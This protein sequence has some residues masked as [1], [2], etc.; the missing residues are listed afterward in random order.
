MEGA[1]LSAVRIA[2]REAPYRQFLGRREPSVVQFPPWS[3]GKSLMVEQN[4]FH[5]DHAFPAT[6]SQD[7]MY[8]ALI[9]P[10]VDK[11][12]EGFQC[13]AL[14]YGQTGTGKSYSMGMTPPDKI[15][16][17]H[18]GILPRA[19]SDIF[20]R[21]TARQENN[22]DAIQVYASFIEIYNEKPFDL[23]GST[24]H[25]PMVAARCQRCTCLPLH[26]QADLNH[27]LEL[28]TG[29][30]RVRPTN[31]NSN[32]SRSHAIVTIHV[33]NKTHHSR[34]N[35]VD[36]AGSEGVRRTGHEG[37]A[38]QEGVNINLGL[39]SIN[40]VVMSMAAGH[41]VIPYRDSVLTTVLQASLTAQSYL[42]FLACISPHRCDLSETLSTLRF[43]TSAKKLRLNPM[44]VARQKQSLAARTTHVLRQALCTSTAIKPNAANHNSLVVPSSKYSTTK[45]LSG[46]LHRTRSE[47][48]MTPKAKK[49]ARKLLELEETTLELSSIHITDN[50]LSLLGFHSDSDKDRH[51]MPPPTGLETRQASSQN[52]TLMG[53]AEEAEHKES[54]KVQQS[55]VANTVPTTVRCQLFNTTIS[56]ISLR[57]SN[58]Q[59]E[60][61][62]IQPMEETIVASPQQ[63]CLR[64]SM[65]LANSMR[66]QN[67]GAIPKVTNLRRS[68]RL[69]GIR[70][71]ATSVV[72]KNE[73]D[74]IPRPRGAVQKKR[75]RKV[76]PAPK[77][78]MANNTRCFLDLL[79]NGNVKQLQEIPGIGPKF[80]FSL[81]L[82]RSRLGC[83]ENLFQ[84]KSLPIWSG[85]K[86][87]RFCQINCL[88]T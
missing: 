81:A 30:R 21:V 56:P 69:A 73:T 65:R 5:F 32:S 6:I 45:P 27:I 54:S 49:R 38:R 57:A 47:L 41:T 64:R 84:V 35:I 42:T 85:N 48:G 15:L 9:L 40:K 82:H 62:G 87:E 11:L 70:E 59:R 14:A 36:L 58:S 86:W 8:Q 24:P 52:S 68:T 43:G 60:L 23:L 7:E 25:M 34:M 67:Y 46:V 31:M 83:F 33:K 16:P 10:L 19:L 18:L 22:K 3:D 17:E 26:S 74:A 71:H 50:S 39:L 80:A 66:S 79:N 88:D 1:K 13:T 20:E 2:V 72:V 51:L 77:A 12:L 4:E 61:S 29:N 75:P 76:K 78:W 28:G 44:Q 53:I 63:P 37:V 55:I